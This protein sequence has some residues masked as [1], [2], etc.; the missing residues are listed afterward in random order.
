MIAP[1][2][3]TFFNSA[4]GKVSKSDAIGVRK[5]KDWINVR[6]RL[7]LDVRVQLIIGL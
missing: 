5:E 6:Q 1:R 4:Y 2:S 3:Q 7:G